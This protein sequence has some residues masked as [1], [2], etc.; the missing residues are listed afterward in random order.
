MR[1]APLFPV[2]RALFARSGNECAFTGCIQHLVNDKNQFIGQLCHIEAANPGGP[3]FN[4]QQS[5]D[6]RRAYENLILLCYPHHIETDDAEA[7]S[8]Q[9]LKD[10]KTEHEQKSMEWSFS[11]S[12]ELLSKLISE[13][14]TYWAQ[15]EIMNTILHDLPELAIEVNAKGTFREVLAHARDLVK[16]IE[17]VDR[18]FEESDRLLMQDLVKLLERLGID[19]A[20][21]ESIP[22]YDNPFKTATGKCEISDFVTTSRSSTSISCT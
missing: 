9:Q 19:P 10:M 2:V 16:D 11:V 13:M 15:I 5:D 21:V 20:G 22:Y 14:E 18:Y 6:E 4:E 17:E 12:D 3:R 1:K 7:F 8:V